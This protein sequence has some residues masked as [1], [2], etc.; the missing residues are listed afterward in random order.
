MVAVKGDDDDDHAFLREIFAVAEHDF[1]HVAHA[2]AIHHYVERGNRLVGNA[3]SIVRDLGDLA[4]VHEYHFLAGEPR[5]F[6]ELHH[7]LAHEIIRVYGNH[8]FRLRELD[9]KL[10]VFRKAVAARVKVKKLGIVKLVHLASDIILQALHTAFVPGND[11]RGENHRVRTL[12]GHHAM[13]A[14]HDAHQPRVRFALRAGREDEYLVVFVFMDFFQR[15]NLPL[16]R[17]QIAE[18]ARDFHIVF[19]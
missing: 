13:L 2:Q 5:R 7:K 12:Q 3:E 6:G 8:E 15:D 17:L 4:V 9:D 10:D 1:L 18:R 14:V 19:H 16:L 11:R